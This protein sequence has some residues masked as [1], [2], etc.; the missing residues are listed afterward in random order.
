M[1]ITLDDL[2]NKGTNP[3][4]SSDGMRKVNISEIPVAKEE[5]NSKSDPSYIEE[6][7]G[8]LNSLITSANERR[9]EFEQS[10][11]EENVDQALEDYDP[12]QDDGPVMAVAHDTIPTISATAPA[13]DDV[14]ELDLTKDNQVIEKPTSEEEDAKKVAAEEAQEKAFN[15]IFEEDEEDKELLDIINDSEPDEDIDEDQQEPEELSEEAQKEIVDNYKKEVTELFSK[16]NTVDTSGFTVSNKAI[17]ISKLL[18]IKEPDKRVSDWVMV[19][20]KKPFSMVEFSGI[21][22]QKINPNTRNR[23]SINTKR[24]NYRTLYNHIVGASKDGFENW[25][26]TTPYK[27]VPHFYFAA[28]K[29]TFG[30]LNVVT[31]QCQ[32]PKCSNVFITEHPLESM[33]EIDD[34]HKE[35]FERVFNGDTSSPTEFKE[36]IIPVSPQFAIGWIEPSI[37]SVEIE[38]LLIDNETQQKY[39]RIIGLL[40]FIKQMYFID[41]EH[42]TYVP[43]D[44]QPV[45]RDLAK[46]VKKKLAIYYNILNSLS[47]DQL[48]IPQLRAY[49]YTEQEDYVKFVE[50]ECNC[51]KCGKIVPKT[52]TNAIT[53]LFNRAQS[54]LAANS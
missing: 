51:P 22:L 23:N 12:T 48:A 17:S 4:P 9:K 49:N 44:E 34:A 41:H 47:N 33:Y 43:I 26:K 3:T 50:P 20:S 31:H 32:D 13:M 10:M 2:A 37:Y 27:D 28:Y 11:A 52:E 45:A 6:Q 8:A 25:L 16:R 14:Q 24:D 39:S 5:D 7:F 29:A 18:N 38:P 53:L 40:P 35:E 1:A 42:R 21:E 30:D 19:T 36:E 46:T 15:N 54:P